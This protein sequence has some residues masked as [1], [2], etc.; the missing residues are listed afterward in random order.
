MNSRKISQFSIYTSQLTKFKKK[1]KDIS[2]AL[3]RAELISKDLSAFQR[4]DTLSE[5]LGYKSHSDLVNLT[6]S[7]VQADKQTPLMI[8]SNDAVAHSIA[9]TFW[10]KFC[11]SPD[12]LSLFIS[13]IK[14]LGFKEL[15]PEP[16]IVYPSEHNYKLYILFHLTAKGI[17]FINLRHRFGIALNWSESM[18][19]VKVLGIKEKD[20][21]IKLLEDEVNK[22]ILIE[23]PEDPH[24]RRSNNIEK[25]WDKGFI[26]TLVRILY[27]SAADKNEDYIKQLPHNIGKKSIFA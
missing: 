18:K 19:I 8:F 22:A 16:S 21:L 13:T 1:A 11:G 3:R 20:D 2:W 24:E 6:S 14:Q 4:N 25:P 10:Q 26:V 9:I 27:Y 5:A 7:R 12:T 17:E 15:N 23:G